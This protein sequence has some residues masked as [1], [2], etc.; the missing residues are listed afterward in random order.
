MCGGTATQLI[1][2]TQK[3]TTRSSSEAEYVA[4]AEGFKK[5]LFLRSVWRFLMTS[6]GTRVSM[7]LRTTTNVAIKMGVNY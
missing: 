7:F 3:C 5:A 2:R 4:M 6:L 1:F